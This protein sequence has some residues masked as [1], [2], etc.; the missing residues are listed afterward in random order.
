MRFHISS[1]HRAENCGIHLE[2]RTDGVNS[3]ANWAERCKEVG[4]EF[5]AGGGLNSSHLLFMFVETYAVSK[6]QELMRPMQGRN[7]VV[8]TPVTAI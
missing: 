7:E 5:I 4:V 6:L 3:V 1:V 2:S 8:I